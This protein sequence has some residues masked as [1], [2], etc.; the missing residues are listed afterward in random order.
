MKEMRVV[1]ELLSEL[2]HLEDRHVLLSDV[3]D[4]G[5]VDDGFASDI[6][7][8]MDELILAMSTT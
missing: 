2:G 6:E 1:I 8:A 4:E 7:T 3:D 5:N